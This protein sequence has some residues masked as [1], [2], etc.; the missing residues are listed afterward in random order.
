MRIYTHN[1]KSGEPLVGSKVPH[2]AS[3]GCVGL[4]C[5]DERVSAITEK[6]A[7]NGVRSAAG[8]LLIL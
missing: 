7:G 6:E 1:N 2:G 8:R 4:L 5:E 3:S